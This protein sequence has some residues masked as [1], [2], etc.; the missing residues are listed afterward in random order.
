MLDRFRGPQADVAASC[1]VVWAHLRKRYPQLRKRDPRLQTILVTGASGGD[2]ATVAAVGLA[3]AAVRFDGSTVL[4]MVLDSATRDWRALDSPVPSV[5]IIDALS[6]AQVRTALSAPSGDFAFTIIVAP[7]PQTSP[8]CISLAYAADVA[9][10][11]A[12][13]GRT[14]FGEAQLAVRLLRQAGLA[15]AA[16]LLLTKHALRSGTSVQAD[17]TRLS[18]HGHRIG[19]GDS[20]APPEAVGEGRGQTT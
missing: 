2:D 15:T 9:I 3:E 20:L 14:R 4:V 18:G 6:S 1:A 7:A 19:L 12:T 5:T 8:D 16:A 17:A 11:V 10:L 13:L